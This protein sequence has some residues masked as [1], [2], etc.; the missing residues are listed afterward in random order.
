MPLFSNDDPSFFG[1]VGIAIFPFDI[2]VA[3]EGSA[4]SKGLVGLWN[5]IYWIT[6]LLSWVF[7]PLM[8][9]YWAS[10]EFSKK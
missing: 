7:L 10:G 3:T 2:G 6:F 9:D 5:V 8:M 4:A 1:F